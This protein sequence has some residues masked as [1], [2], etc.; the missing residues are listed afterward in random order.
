VLTRNQRLVDELG[1]RPQE[2]IKDLRI[3]D[4][5]AKPCDPAC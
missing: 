1:D 2:G 5:R 4:H 3:A